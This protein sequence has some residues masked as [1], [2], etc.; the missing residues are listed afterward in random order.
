MAK[1]GKKSKSED[2]AAAGGKLT[3]AQLQYMYDRLMIRD[4][5]GRWPRGA[6]RHDVEILESAYWE[7]AQINYQRQFSGGRADFIDWANELHDRQ[8]ESHMHHITNHWAEIDGNVAHAESYVIA[9]T[10]R[11]DG[12]QNVSSGRYI[13]KLEKRNGEWRILIREMIPE[14]RFVVQSAYD[15]SDY[16]DIS[17]GRQDRGDAAF[18][19]PLPRRP[20]SEKAARLPERDPMRA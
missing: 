20:D 19:R 9:F 13:D 10:R 4:V 6:D 2:K 7:D 5:I 1:N 16:P 12:R 17:I 3:E 18:L 11:P 14:V 15:S 8:Y